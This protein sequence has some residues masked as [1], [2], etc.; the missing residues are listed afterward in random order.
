MR[1]LATILCLYLFGL[2][3]Q[4]SLFPLRT[5]TAKDMSCCAKK[6]K[7]H[8]DCPSKN[9]GCCGGDQ[10]NPFFSSC[11]ICA[12]NALTVKKYTVPQNRPLFY[13]RREYFSKNDQLISQYQADILHPPQ[14]V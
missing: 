8:K 2:C 6:D 12:A 9:N 14:A 5:V 10:C 1:A 7:A 4:P 3:I 13:T 11:P